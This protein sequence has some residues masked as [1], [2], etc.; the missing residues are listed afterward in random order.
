M[1]QVFSTSK[2][3]PRDRFDCWHSVACA[4]VVD[5]DSVAGCRPNFFAEL[6]FEQL[7]ETG[8]VRFE[9]SPM[10]ISHTERHIASRDAGELFVCQQVEGVLAVEQDGREVKLQPGDITILDPSWPYAGQFLVH[11]KLL[12]LKTP[13]HLLE[14]RAGKLRQLTAC[15]IKPRA[16][17]GAFLTMFLQALQ[18]QVGFLGPSA[19]KVI[20]DQAL[21]LVALSLS[22]VFERD[23]PRL[24]NARSLVLTK[25]RA[26]I[27]A[28]LAEPALD[29]E[30][31][32]AAAGVSV[33]YANS[34]LAEHQT[35][36][37]RAILERRLERCRRV[38]EDPSQR[39]RTL[40]DIAYALGFSDM[41]HFGRKFKSAY[42]VSPREYRNAHAFQDWKRA[43]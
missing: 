21:D 15:A 41:T 19:Q 9:N 1:K 7:A 33:R 20:Q 39:H 14:M 10:S 4:T 35:S 18:A 42:G 31:V 34:V 30:T 11:S 40:G 3:H 17:D 37:G 8:V 13:R 23:N 12:V 38:L 24:S 26:A 2:L 22:H 28:R 29:A 25:V 6:Q 27:E 36:I 43:E 32:A 5:H 16:G